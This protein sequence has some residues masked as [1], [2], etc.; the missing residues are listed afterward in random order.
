MALRISSEASIRSLLKVN[1]MKIVAEPSEAVLL[2]SVTPVMLC[3]DF[4]MRL[5][6]SRST[7]SGD[8]PGYGIDTTMKGTSTSGFWLTRSFFR[9]IR[10]RHIIATI[11]TIVAMGFLTLKSDRNI[12]V[13]FADR[14]RLGRRGDVLRRGQLHRLAVM[15]GRARRAQHLVAGRE[16]R[17]DLPLAGAL[18]ARADGQVDLGQLVALDLPR[19]A[20]IARLHQGRRRQHQ[21][22]GRL[23]LDA[24]FRIQAGHARLQLVGELDEHLDLARD[25][26]RGRVDPLDLALE[27]LARI[28]VDAEQHGLATLTTPILSAD[29]RPSKRMLDGSITLISSLPIWAVSPFDTLR[30]DTMPSNGARTLV[31][32]S[33]WRAW[34]RR[35]LA[36]T[37]S[38]CALLRRTSASSSACI[39]VMPEARRV[40][41]R[42]IIRSAWSS[43]WRAERTASSADVRLSRIDVS[44]SRTSRSPLR[45]ASPFSFSTCSTT[46][47]TSARRSARRSGWIEPVMTGPAASEL[48]WTVNRSSADTSSLGCFLSAP[49]APAAGV[50]SAALSPSGAGL[51]QATSAEAM[52]RATRV[53]RNIENL[54]EVL[55]CVRRKPAFIMETLRPDL[56]SEMRNR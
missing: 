42:S 7:V 38:L 34:A 43:T 17:L 55:D 14:G 15:H 28:A 1:F 2:V 52:A 3:S 23:R 33:C 5:T 35:A 19:V 46:A 12:S 48:L 26:I 39:D 49:F 32:S 53:F 41:L 54:R 13:S 37:T 20:G 9:A 36:A 47:P 31:R 51:P 29:T 45:T 8:A 4:S 22:V 16:A 6:T 10:P 50:P 44:S 25:G 27:I 30:S 21:R 40:L 18:V 11:S 24:P 56:G